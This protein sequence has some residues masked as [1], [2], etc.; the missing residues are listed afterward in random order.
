MQPL[1]LVVSQGDYTLTMIDPSTDKAI[2]VIP[3]GSA[4]GHGHEVAVSPNGQTAY[5][6]I[7]GNTGVG[8]PGTNGR[9]ILAIDVATHK[10]IGNVEFPSGVRPHCAVF[11]ARHNLLYV[12]TE[13][14]HTVSIVDPRTLKIVGAV[15]TGQPESHMFTI[16]SDGRLGYTANVGPGTVS[17]L[18]LVKRKV[19]AIVPISKNTQR[20]SISPDNSMVF[21]SDQTKPQ[22]AVIDTATNKVK[23]WVLLPGVGYGTTPTKDGRWL[24]VAVPGGNQVA[25]V[26][27]RTLKIDH[28]IPVCGAP[29]EILVRSDTSSTAYVSCMSS[30]NVGVLDLSNWRMKKSIDIGKKPDGLGWAQ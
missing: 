19:I 15:P 16:S 27:L 10:V 29:Q 26:N 28:I 22:L 17:V 1:L 13:L 24:L 7:Y 18:D 6:P 8:K 2:A 14:N 20:I 11:D 23:T 21:T 9:N 30:H 3:T 5:V 12:T 25:V 4:E